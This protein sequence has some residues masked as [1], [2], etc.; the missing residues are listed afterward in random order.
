M[1]EKIWELIRCY[2]FKRWLG[3]NRHCFAWYVHSKLMNVQ[4]EQ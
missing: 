3:F 2:E 1:L 4:R